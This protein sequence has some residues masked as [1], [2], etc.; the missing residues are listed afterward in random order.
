[1]SDQIPVMIPN[2][3][4]LVA[5][6][7]AFHD[8]PKM[9]FQEIPLLSRGVNARFPSLNRHRFILKGNAPNRHP[10]IFI[11]LDEFCIIQRPGLIIFRQ[12]RSALQHILV[13]FHKCRRTPWACIQWKCPT[14]RLNRFFNQ[15]DAER[16][17]VVDAECFQLLV[18]IRDIGKTCAAEVATVDRNPCQG[19]ADAVF[20]IVIGFQEF[21]LFAFRKPGK[22]F[23]RGIRN[24]GPDPPKRLKRFIRVHKNRNL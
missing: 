1:M 6:P 3:D 15:R 9:V 23:G 13:I 5:K 7:F 10:L 4:L 22:D 14:C 19:I 17:V 12:Q 16:M 8:R 24:G 2:H 11:G 21:A 20:G 18:L